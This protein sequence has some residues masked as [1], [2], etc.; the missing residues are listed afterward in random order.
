MAFIRLDDFNSLL[1]WNPSMMSLSVSLSDKDVK[2]LDDLRSKMHETAKE[3][4]KKENELADKY[5]DLYK[6]TGNLVTIRNA[7]GLA[8]WF[9]NLFLP[10][11]G[12]L[13]SRMFPATGIPSIDSLLR[14]NGSALIQLMMPTCPACQRFSDPLNSALAALGL[15]SSLAVALDVSCLRTGTCALSTFLR[16]HMLERNLWDGKVPALFALRLLSGGLSFTPILVDSRTAVDVL[17]RDIESALAINSAATAATGL[18]L[19][20]DA[21][22]A[23]SRVNEMKGMKDYSRE[24]VELKKMLEKTTSPVSDKM[25]SFLR[26]ADATTPQ[27]KILSGLV[28][29]ASEEAYSLSG[30]LKFDADPATNWSKLV[31]A[32]LNI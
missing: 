31:R 22:R 30:M 29:A 18:A 27:S 14:F 11:A 20:N 2:S 3:I 9:N 5:A 21:M 8:T 24:L 23:A 6:E 15:P 25:L 12:L 19:A 1:G 28:E 4:H 26:V 7:S 16:R 13:Q 17:K 10:S 32:Y